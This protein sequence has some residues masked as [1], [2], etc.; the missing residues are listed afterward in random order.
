[1]MNSNFSEL[2]ADGFRDKRVLITGGMGFVGSTLAIALV[3]AGARVT[4]SD[5]MLPGYGGNLFN[6]APIK[7]RVTVNFSD[8]RDV[9]VMNY[10]VQ[11]QDYVFHL[12]GQCDHILSLT[13]PFPDI[14][15]N[16]TG[17]AVLLEAVKHHN[18]AARVIYTGTRGEYGP[19][20]KLP[21]NED[22]PTNPRGIYEISR[23]AAEQIVQVYHE[24]HGVRSIMLRLTN[25]YG[26][27]AQM[28]HSRYGVVN[29][30]M[31][32]ALDNDTI[33]VFG[34]GQILRDFLYVDDCVEAILASALCDNAYG[35]MMNVGIDQPTSF[36]ELAET[37]VRV[38]QTGRWEFAPFSPER[39][40]QEP[41]DFYSDITKIRALV[42][43]EPR[44]TLD[45]GIRQS[46]AFYRQH[47]E[48][49]W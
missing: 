36:L 4:L 39:K 9:H 18:P 33:K 10:L 48:H 46:I 13:N 5:A 2:V 21:V 14:D 44:T 35:Q 3:E 41:G 23:L 26:P 27:R 8:V 42:G 29:W 11:R 7:D 22:A 47:K 1:M 24:I 25:L 16:I 34:D 17:T 43:W 32:L 45:D 20:T 37:I 40:A 12:A 38:A 28:M 30:F 31:R 6:I 49:Y 19:A 15:I